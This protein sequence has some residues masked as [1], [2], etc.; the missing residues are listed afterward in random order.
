ME[1]GH[2][3]EFVERASLLVCPHLS[4]LLTHLVF[5][6]KNRE[7][8]LTGEVGAL[9]NFGDFLFVIFAIFVVP[10]PF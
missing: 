5:S 3:G 1:F 10:F 7:L 2:F 9:L 4:S 6:I 8:S